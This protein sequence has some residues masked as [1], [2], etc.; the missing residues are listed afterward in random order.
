MRLFRR[1]AREDDRTILLRQLPRGAVCAEI[2][3]LEG[4]FSERIIALT[5]PRRLHLI[6]PWK[7]EPGETYER[8]VYG[9]AHVRDQARMDAMCGQVHE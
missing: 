3:V 6:D 5:R 8:A 2:G 9:R 7:F 4:D 1:T